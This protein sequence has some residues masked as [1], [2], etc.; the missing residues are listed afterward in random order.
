MALNKELA[1]ESFRVESKRAYASSGVYSYLASKVAD[2]SEIVDIA[3][4]AKAK[5]SAPLLLFTAVH[6]L[7]L[8]NPDNPLAEYYQ[9]VTKHP[10]TQLNDLYPLFRGFV[11]ENREQILRIL[12]VS[13]A[14]KTVINRSAC[15]RSMIAQVANENGWGSTHI[16]DIGCSA[17]FHLLVDRWRI[18]YLGA[19]TVGPDDSPV[20]FSTKVLGDKLP[21][22]G[23]IPQIRRRIGIDLDAFN[24]SSASDRRW[25]L[26]GLNP[27]DK[28]TMLAMDQAFQVLVQDPPDYVIGDAGEKL[29]EVFA[30]ISDDVPVIVMHS[31]TFGMMNP[32]QKQSI[33]QALSMAS[34]TRPVI[35][36]GMEGKGDKCILSITNCED[37]NNKIV[38]E[39]DENGF[40]IRWY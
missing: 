40:W 26:A 29:P 23:D 11:L 34:N 20:S 2:D 19:G 27:E 16:I 38:G 1:A 30:G 15:L 8:E 17:G 31:L 4:Q 36:I 6:S 24:I 21:E 35:R 3:I 22:L 10:K 33:F 32:V 37:N 5:Q 14:N 28:Q 13:N 9:T 7:L 25:L 12:R 18:N 39:S